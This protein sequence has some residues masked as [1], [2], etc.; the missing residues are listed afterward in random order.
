MGIGL[1]K[2]KLKLPLQLMPKTS[3]L[4]VQRLLRDGVWGTNGAKRAPTVVRLGRLEVALAAAKEVHV[5]AV[6]VS[7]NL[8][9]SIMV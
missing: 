7:D 4:Q 6:A 3:L 5:D 2:V 1:P 8:L 9:G